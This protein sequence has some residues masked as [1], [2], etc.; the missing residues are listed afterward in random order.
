MNK[1]SFANI[2]IGYSGEVIDNQFKA[3]RDFKEKFNLELSFII[4]RGYSIYF[5]MFP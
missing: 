2:Q 4:C 3:P 1:T 5:I